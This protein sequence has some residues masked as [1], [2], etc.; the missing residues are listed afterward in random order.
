[1]SEICPL[2]KNF[3]TREEFYEYG[4]FFIL[5]W[6]DNI[7]ICICESCGSWVRGATI[8]SIL[9]KYLRNPNEGPTIV[10]FI[11]QIGAAKSFSEARRV[12]SMGGLEINNNKIIDP[13][14]RLSPTAKY[15]II[16]GRKTFELAAGE[17]AE[18]YENTD[19]W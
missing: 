10:N 9:P 11:C 18:W 2:C 1:M 7:V 15:T 12:I 13:M 5:P 16:Y 17:V 19:H 4:R 14:T 3:L 8:N 6:K